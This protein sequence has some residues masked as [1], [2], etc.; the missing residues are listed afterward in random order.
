[1]SCCGFSGAGGF[2]PAEFA[3]AF[4]SAW[5]HHTLIP[6]FIINN[7]GGVTDSEKVF[8]RTPNNPEYKAKDFTQNQETARWVCAD[9]CAPFN[10]KKTALKLWAYWYVTSEGS[11][12]TPVKWQW[13]IKALSD[14]ASM[15]FD[16]TY[17][18]NDDTESANDLMYISPVLTYTPVTAGT[19]T[20]RDYFHIM[21]RRQNDSASGTARL[22]A[23]QIAW[24][25]DPT[26]AVP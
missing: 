10:W 11:H 13:H 24:E 4:P 22:A 18:N 17:T 14:G 2:D 20:V 26:I 15:S 23:L 8:V 19:L 12:G 16:Q 3:T 7:G 25:I 21:F 6:A 5:W 1:M 9:W